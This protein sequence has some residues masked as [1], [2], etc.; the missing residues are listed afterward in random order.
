MN[1]KFLL[2]HKSVYFSFAAGCNLFCFHLAFV[3]Y[4]R[5]VLVSLLQPHPRLPLVSPTPHGKHFKLDRR[6][7]FVLFEGIRVSSHKFE[8][9]YFVWFVMES[10]CCRCCCCCGFCYIHVAVTCC[11][12]IHACLSAFALPFSLANGNLCP[13]LWLLHYLITKRYYDATFG[14]PSCRHIERRA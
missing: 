7:V 4:A 5:R 2:K 10:I 14:Q 12:N 11:G 6:S 1:I 9:R 8:L 3:L 13:E